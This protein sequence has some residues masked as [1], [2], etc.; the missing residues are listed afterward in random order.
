MNYDHQTYEQSTHPEH[1][2]RNIIFSFLCFFFSLSFNCLWICHLFQF[3]KAWLVILIAALIFVGALVGAVLSF[4]SSHAN[5]FA[6]A[7]NRKNKT[8]GYYR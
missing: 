5:Y 2:I 6:Y 8:H 7:R 3:D 1:P 4:K